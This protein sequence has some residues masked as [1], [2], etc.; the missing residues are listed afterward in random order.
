MQRNIPMATALEAIQ[1][2]REGETSKFKEIVEALLK[3]KSVENIEAM[4]IEHAQKML[5]EKDDEEDMDDDDE[6]DE[7]DDDDEENG[8]GEGEED[9]DD[10]DENKKG[11]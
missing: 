3:E 4:K 9:D 1:A 10:K 8:E 7:E 5:D 2:L 11:E 6:D